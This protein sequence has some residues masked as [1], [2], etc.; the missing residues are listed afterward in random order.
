MSSSITDNIMKLAADKD[1]AKEG[2]QPPQ[3]GEQ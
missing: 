2:E 1:K 3:E